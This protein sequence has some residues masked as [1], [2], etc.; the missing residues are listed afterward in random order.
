MRFAFP[1]AAVVVGSNFI[2]GC[3]APIGPASE[4]TSQSTGVA[5]PAGRPAGAAAF[6]GHWYSAFDKRVSWHEAKKLCESMGGYLCC[7]ETRQ[8]QA[9]IAKLAG[10][11]YLFLGAT[12]EKEE[13]AWRWVNGKPFAYACW[14]DG[15]PNNWGDN[16]NYLAT[17][18]GGEWVDVA[19]EGEDFWM[20]TG[21]I[22]EW[23]K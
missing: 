6:G 9:F 10:G 3:A 23:E 15:Q 1:L 17:Y 7:I 16:E 2:L 20:P 21:F 13:G 14:M 4:V 8:E 12:D 5:K 18:D 11:R 19:V 22:C